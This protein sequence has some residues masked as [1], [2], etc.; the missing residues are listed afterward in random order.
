M[1]FFISTVR[2]LAGFVYCLLCIAACAAALIF[3]WSVIAGVVPLVGAIEHGNVDLP[4]ITL[5]VSFLAILL[6]VIGFDISF[7]L[8]GKYKTK[9]SE[10]G[11]G[12]EKNFK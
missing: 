9:D 7:R 6:A 10:T 12:S 8:T 11:H 1:R 2:F 3:L 4:P 5:V